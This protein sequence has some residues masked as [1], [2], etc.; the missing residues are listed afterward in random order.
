MLLGSDHRTAQTRDKAHLLNSTSKLSNTSG[1]LSTN[2]DI[3]KKKENNSLK[4][5]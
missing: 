3:R 1:R 4:V 2:T 5:T